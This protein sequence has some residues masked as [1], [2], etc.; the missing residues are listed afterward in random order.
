MQWQKQDS[1]CR[2][3]QITCTRNLTTKYHL[4]IITQFTCKK[5]THSFEGTFHHKFYKQNI[6]N[7][8]SSNRIIGRC[9]GARTSVCTQ[10]PAPGDR[11]GGAGSRGFRY[12][13][14]QGYIHQHW[15]FGFES[16]G[17]FVWIREK[18]FCGIMA[19]SSALQ[20]L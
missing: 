4:Y 6:N 10:G 1:S 16:I 17:S 15:V 11:Q 5:K 20:V 2:G 13:L 14:R 18:A 3:D 7:Y 9:A 8:N 12:P 19:F